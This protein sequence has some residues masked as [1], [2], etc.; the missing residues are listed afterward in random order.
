M[1]TMTPCKLR[2]ECVK[3]WGNALH[4]LAKLCI[5]LDNDSYLPNYSISVLNRH[6]PLVNTCIALMNHYIPS[7]NQ[8]IF[9]LNHQ[10]FLPN[11]EYL[12]IRPEWPHLPSHETSLR[13]FYYSIYIWRHRSPISV[14]RPAV[15]PFFRPF[16]RIKMLRRN[17]P[18]LGG[19]VGN[20]RPRKRP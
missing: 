17:R 8:Y 18:I 13:S 9:L 7:S 2:D 14:N 1:W 10:I 20:F 19:W 6:I 15:L 16:L 3:L 11:Y 4:T 5:F 12:P